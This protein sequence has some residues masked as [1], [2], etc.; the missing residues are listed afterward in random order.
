MR[1]ITSISGAAFAAFTTITLLAC[2][3][4]HRAE[5]GT[6][7]G[8]LIP[9]RDVLDGGPAASEIY[10]VAETPADRSVREA[11][12][13]P[14]KNLAA[15]R[16]P[17]EKV[18]N[19]CR[20]AADVNIFVNWSALQASGVSRDMPITLKLRGRS[21]GETLTAILDQAGGD[22]RSL[23]YI[24]D[25]GTIT[26]STKEDME[27]PKYQVVKVFDIRD[28][29][30]QPDS[31]IQPP[32]WGASPEQVASGAFDPPPKDAGPTREQVVQEILE[33]IKTNV[34]PEP[35]RDA[36]GKIGAI[37]ELNGQLIVNQTLANQRA[38]HKFLN[39]LRDTRKLQ[40]QIEANL[41]KVGGGGFQ[42]VPR[43]EQK[44]AP[45]TQ[46]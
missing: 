24:I 9:Y 17:L 34:A 42:D 16:T 43:L 38:V 27:S 2:S 30:V 8:Q 13:R 32:I 46:P 4:G 19:F 10:N 3:G 35:W 20:N 23:A 36:G 39:D 28:M 21:L 29:L 14:L 5:P 18:I 45:A 40:L 1:T 25:G 6:S 33:T 12:Q 15:D 22:S 37:R 41:L 31:N 11:L 44:P 7:Q 26:I